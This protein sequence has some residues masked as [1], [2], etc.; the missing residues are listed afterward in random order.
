MSLQGQ[1]YGLPY[2]SD[3]EIFS[4]NEKM[5]QAAAFSSP[6]ATWGTT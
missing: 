6:P 1:L 3:F 5:M 2:Y 4:Y